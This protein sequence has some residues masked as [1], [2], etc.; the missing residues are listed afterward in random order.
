M[1][2]TFCLFRMSWLVL[3]NG[4]VKLEFDFSRKGRDSGGGQRVGDAPLTRDM[5]S[6]PPLLGKE[7]GNPL[8]CVC[9]CA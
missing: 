9:G 4:K 6:H 8:P 2:A 7:S 1:L 5:H 3:K